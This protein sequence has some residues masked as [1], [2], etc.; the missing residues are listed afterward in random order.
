MTVTGAAYA[1]PHMYYYE[2]V[3]CCRRILLTEVLIFIAPQSGKQ[4]T[5]ACIFAFVGLLGFE[6][7]RPHVDSTDSWLY[8]MVSRGNAGIR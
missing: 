8:R 1:G 6:L 7:L 3:E 4:A 2:V 5:M